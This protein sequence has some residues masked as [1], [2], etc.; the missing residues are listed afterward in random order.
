MAQN[1]QTFTYD[2]LAL[3]GPFSGYNL[4]LYFYLEVFWIF[5]DSGLGQNFCTTD[6][7]AHPTLVT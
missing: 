7:G 4:T 1:L 6:I 2:I 5:P 3:G